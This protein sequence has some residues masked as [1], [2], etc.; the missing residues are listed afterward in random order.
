VVKNTGEHPEVFYFKMNKN[1]HQNKRNE[2]ENGSICTRKTSVIAGSCNRLSLRA[3]V[4]AEQRQQG[5]KEAKG[6]VADKDRTSQTHRPNDVKKPIECMI[7][8]IAPPCDL[9]CSSG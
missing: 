7:K 1:A 9:P 3:H 5:C 6:E 2:G 4:G 8:V